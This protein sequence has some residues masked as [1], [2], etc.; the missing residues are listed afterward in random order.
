M[1]RGEFFAKRTL[2]NERGMALLL[3]LAI[4]AL[5]A[6]LLSELSFSTL[7]DL[8]LAE[9]YRDTTRSYYIA[10]GGIQVGQMI[11]ADDDNAYD[12]YD[13]LWARGISNYPVGDNGWVS[14][15][16]TPLDGRI[17]LNDLVSSSGNIDAVVK[18]RCLRL[19]D[20]LE[21]AQPHSHVDALI[22]WLDP[23]DDPQPA[24]AE[25]GYYA[26]QDPATYC[27]NG[28][29]DTLEELQLIAGFTEEEIKKLRPH[30]SLYGDNKIHL[31]SASAEVLYALAEEMTIDMAEAIVQQR[32]EKPFESVEE[33]KEQPNW[34][35]FYWAINGYV[36]V[37]ANYYRIDT[38]ASVNDGER[39]ARATVE[40]D[41]NRIVYF[42][43]R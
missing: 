24:G 8:R 39:R 37:K 34:E 26:L 36:Q 23:D 10:K 25:A 14:I 17:N 28:P 5:L 6:A 13:E 38:R 41:D 18:D 29:M 40:K 3:V 33:L 21:I 43:I 15:E 31:N 2:A 19:F 11:L 9:T 35:S 42:E 27:K 7:V 30:V 22:D 16:V 32:N 20:I 4:T 1:K 12:G